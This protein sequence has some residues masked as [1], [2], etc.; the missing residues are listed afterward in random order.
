MG[1][2]YRFDAGQSCYTLHQLLV[3]D[4][5]AYLVVTAQTEIQRYHQHFSWIEAGVDR[6]QSLQ[7][8]HA[9]TGADQHQ[10][11]KAPL[12][13]NQQLPRVETAQTRAV[14]RSS[15]ERGDHTCARSAERGR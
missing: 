12:R 10:K 13:D 3:Q 11:R 6:L 9:Q 7:A 1:Q 5:P 4:L 2:T 15:F 14:A 8:A